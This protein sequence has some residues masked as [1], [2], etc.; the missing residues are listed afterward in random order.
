MHSL[1]PTEILDQPE[2]LAGYLAWFGWFALFALSL[3]G[4]GHLFEKRWMG[5]IGAQ[6]SL[7]LQIAFGTA[8][9]CLL[10]SVLTQLF[11]PAVLSWI[12]LGLVIGGLKLVRTRAWRWDWK[13]SGF[14][15]FLYIVLA[16]SVVIR[17][18]EGFFLHRHADAFICYLSAGRAW[19]NHG[20]AEF[21]KNPVYFLS[22]MW[23]QQFLFG[24]L[25][26]ASGPNAGLAQGQRFAQWCT[27]FAA[28]LGT[29]AIVFRLAIQ[30]GSNRTSA[31]IAALAASTVPILRW[32]QNLAKND[33]GVAFW[34][35]TGFSL[36]Q[37]GNFF[38]AGIFLGLAVIGKL[39]LYI[40]LIPVF[41]VL[42]WRKERLRAYLALAAGGALA[43]LPILVRNFTWTGNPVFPFLNGIFKSAVLTPSFAT[44]VTSLSNPA[45]DILKVD[46]ILAPF[47][48][49]PWLVL[50]PVALL[51]S[52]F[53]KPLTIR[54]GKAHAWLIGILT[55]TLIFCYGM[56]PQS[57]LRYLGP[58][59]QMLACLSVV[60]WQPLLKTS[61]RRPLWAI[62]IA[63]V[64]LSNLNLFTFAQ[65]AKGKY[66]TGT[67][68]VLNHSAGKAKKWI[69]DHAG[70]RA[71]ATLGD[72][73]IYYMSGYAYHEIS[74]YAPLDLALLPLQTGEEMV[75]YLR[76]EKY[77]FVVDARKI[78]PWDCHNPE[79]ANILVSHLNRFPQARVFDKGDV[80]IYDLDQLVLIA[81]AR[82]K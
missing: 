82:K 21:V 63:V 5:K 23:E 34:A 33:M 40:A 70:D 59:L 10:L 77:R 80:V 31:L 24:M 69:R 72:D 58:V 44:T 28:D 62:G 37:S 46:F 36:V 8:F 79:G 38:L 47:K 48:E 41:I 39:S 14:D 76:N 12:C 65:I 81:S 22:S 75:R 51:L 54:L 4:W 68:E 25:P 2:S 52:I 32:M 55:A 7:A 13:T 6:S 61:S 49:Q 56:L 17:L 1:F 3:L 53:S 73:Q 67:A 60:S 42:I 11:R 29:I 19:V 74:Y 18:C 57:E 50:A 26:V 16:L 64:A 27:A 35:L 20:F 78:S 71:T 30:L 43:A 15:N 9:Y 66:T 45:T